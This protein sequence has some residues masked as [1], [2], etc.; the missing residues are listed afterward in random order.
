[1][2]RLV[3]RHYSAHSHYWRSLL[4]CWFLTSLVTYPAFGDQLGGSVELSDIP[5][6]G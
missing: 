2:P 4:L 5:V 3:N 6:E 1:M